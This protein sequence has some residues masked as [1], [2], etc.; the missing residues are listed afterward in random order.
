MA[1]AHEELHESFEWRTIY[2]AKI[3]LAKCFDTVDYRQALRV[4]RRLGA[5]ISLLGV[6]R[7]FY[8][9][10]PWSGKGTRPA[11]PS[12]VNEG[13]SKVAHSVAPCWQDS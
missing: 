8:D 4:W 6:I 11:K 2:G 7:F 12:A 1:S 10:K 13:Y 9:L 3:D 5:P